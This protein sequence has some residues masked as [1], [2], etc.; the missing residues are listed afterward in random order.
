MSRDQVSVSIHHPEKNKVVYSKFSVQFFRCTSPRNPVYH[1]KMNNGRFVS[2]IISFI[3]IYCV[4]AFCHTLYVFVCEADS[5]FFFLRSFARTLSPV[6]R[7]L[8]THSHQSRIWCVIPF[9][10]HP[11]LLCCFGHVL[12]NERTHARRNEQKKKTYAR[13]RHRRGRV[14]AGPKCVCVRTAHRSSLCSSTL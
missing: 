10:C 14:S 2:V 7:P 4:A 9:C 11:S 13:I 8:F 1:I 12:P 5:F 6:F 3:V